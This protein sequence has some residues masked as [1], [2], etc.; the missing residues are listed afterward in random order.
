[1]QV[2][3]FHPDGFLLRACVV[4]GFKEPHPHVMGMVD[5]DE[6]AIAEA[7]WGEDMNWIPKVR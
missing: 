7:M 3:D 2:P 1:M 4:F 6:E 5:D